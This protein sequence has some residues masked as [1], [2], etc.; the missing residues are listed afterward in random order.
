VVDEVGLDLREG[1]SGMLFDDFEECGA[2]N[3]FGYVFRLSYLHVIIYTEKIN[4]E[5]F[6]D[7]TPTF[8]KLFCAICGEEAG[9]G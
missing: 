1:K 3:L 4:R 7:N 9:E 2:G 8:L 5:I 6:C